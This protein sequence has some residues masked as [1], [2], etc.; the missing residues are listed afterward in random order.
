M[1]ADDGPVAQI[2]LQAEIVLRES[3]GRAGGTRSRR[4]SLD[5]AA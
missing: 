3:V 4:R 2:E 5:A 1:K